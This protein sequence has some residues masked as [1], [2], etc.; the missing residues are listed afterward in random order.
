MEK[1]T[2]RTVIVLC[3]IDGISFVF[4]RAYC[5]SNALR[6]GSIAIAPQR[7]TRPRSPQQDRPL[8][9]ND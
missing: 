9:G 6:L 7:H 8:R 4:L 2:L 3:V 1:R 5:N